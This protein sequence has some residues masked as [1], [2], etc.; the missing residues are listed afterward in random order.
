[1]YNVK[2]KHLLAYVSAA[3]LISSNALAA[4][5]SVTANIAF[6]TVLSINKEHDIDFGTVKAG[7]TGTHVITT[8]GSVSS[9]G[10]GVWISGT[11]TA[12]ELTI[13]GSTTQTLTIS[14]GSFTANESVTPSVATCSYNGGGVDADCSMAAQAAPGAGKTLLIG[15]TVTMDGSAAAGDSST[16]SFTITVNYT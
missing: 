16:P 7:V 15:V 4:T 13:S 11:P 2:T 9:T 10:N 12:G 1:M 3:A 5:Q 6:D 14:A 8:A